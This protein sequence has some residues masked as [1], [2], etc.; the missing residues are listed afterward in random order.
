MTEHGPSIG[1]LRRLELYFSVRHSLRTMRQFAELFEY[2]YDLV[3]IF[4]SVAEAGLQAVFHLAAVNAQ[5][6][7]VDATYHALGAAGL[8][9]MGIGESTNIP[10]ETVRRKVRRL[11]DMG[12]LSIREKDKSIYIPGSTISNPRVLDILNQHV[13]EVGALVKTVQFYNKDYNKV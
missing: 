11:V 7:D 9:V 5:E 2:D 1:V 6:I 3:M 10:R 13:N 8:S 4:L 12:Y